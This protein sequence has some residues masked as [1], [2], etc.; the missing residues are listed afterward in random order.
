LQTAE[1][2]RRKSILLIDDEPGVRAAIFQ[3]L[4]KSHYEIIEAASPDAAANIWSSRREQIDLILLD[5][6]LPGLS[7]P[8]FARE[9]LAHETCAPIIYITGVGQENLGRFQVPADAPVLLKPFSVSE[10][11]EVV[12]ATLAA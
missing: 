11:R 12:A 6:L 10:L 5:V 4:R 8:E 1:K 7:G 2:R 3:A 9:I